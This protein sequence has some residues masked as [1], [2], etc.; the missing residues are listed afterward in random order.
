VA[1]AEPEPGEQEGEGEAD[2]RRF[3]VSLTVASVFGVLLAVGLAFLLRDVA[4]AALTPIVWTIAGLILAVLLLPA[5]ELLSRWLPRFVA[6]AIVLIA[7]A[8]FVLLVGYRFVD[9][10]S[11]EVSRLQEELPRAA[12][13]LQQGSSI[14]QDFQFSQR[15]GEFV[16]QLP[17]QSVQPSEAAS[18]VVTYSVAGTLT[19]FL[20][21]YAPK[22]FDAAFAQIPDRDRR[23][24]LRRFF[25][26]AMAR[27]RRYALFSGA[28]ML[29]VG[30]ISYVL[31]RLT[32]VPAPTPLAVVAGLLSTLPYF[33]VVLGTLPILLLAAGLNSWQEALWL[34]AI[35]LALQVAHVQVWKRVVQPRSL[36]VGPA[37][38]SIVALIGFDL[39]GLGG[40]LFGTVIGVFVVAL[41]DAA[42]N[43]RFLSGTSPPVTPEGQARPPTEERPAPAGQ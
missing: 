39:Y 14:L 6:A 27:T 12:S 19:L 11:S 8:A 20:M 32:D 13:E 24:E 26:V 9:D 28:G 37:I 33:G 23:R 16:Q 2:G 3:R 42:A 43:T 22:L 35:M 25:I 30:V 21:L 7:L 36:Y 15:V 29:V 38:I 10:L 34:A 40:M 4:R 17:D 41:G 5:V 31:C 18:T 1:E